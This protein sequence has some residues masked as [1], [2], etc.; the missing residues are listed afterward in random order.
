MLVI[1]RDFERRALVELE[2]RGHPLTRSLISIL[3]HLDE[4]GTTTVT[5]AAHRAGISKQAAG[6][7]VDELVRRGYV[8]RVPHPDDGRAVL[9]TFTAAGEGLVR[10][11]EQT[12]RTIE[13][14]YA[15][16]IGREAFEALSSVLGQLRRAVEA[17]P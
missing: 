2:R 10:D 4:A 11:I 8:Q 3:P 14:A 16:A 12:I 7:L 1:H 17:A 6:K 9:V 15:E 13:D 5:A